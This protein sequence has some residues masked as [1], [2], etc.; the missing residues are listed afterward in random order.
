MKWDT[1]KEINTDSVTTF[2]KVTTI[3]HFLTSSE[4]VVCTF[5]M[6]RSSEI[7]QRW[8]QSQSGMNVESHGLFEMLLLPKQKRYCNEYAENMLRGGGGGHIEVVLPGMSAR[9]T[10]QDTDKRK[11]T[12]NFM[13]RSSWSGGA[14]LQPSVTIGCSAGE[15]YSAHSETAPRFP[16]VVA[17]HYRAGNKPSV[18]RSRR[19]GTRCEDACGGVRFLWLRRRRHGEL[20]S[21]EQLSGG[22]RGRR[23]GCPGGAEAWSLNISFIFNHCGIVGLVRN[24]FYYC[25]NIPDHEGWFKLWHWTR[26]AYFPKLSGELELIVVWTCVTFC[27]LFRNIELGCVEIRLD[28]I[29]HTGVYRPRT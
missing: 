12:A 11:R 26:L 18:A 23:E 10:G 1:G 15:D 3:S 4:W 28:A 29:W 27:F 22:G 21:T 24:G 20:R 19:A 8:F 7:M 25:Y 13:V 16:S 5:G 2:C 14:L 17:A 6:T 9:Y